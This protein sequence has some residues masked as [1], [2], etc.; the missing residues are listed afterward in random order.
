MTTSAIDHDK[1]SGIIGR[2]GEAAIDPAAWPA[3]MDDLCRATGTTGAVLLQADIRTPDVPSTVSM[4]E[5]LQRYFAQGWH[6]ADP[7]ARGVPRAM[8]GEVITDEDCV[9]PDQ[10]RI[11]PMYNEVLRPFGLQWFAGIGFWAGS[12]SWVLT[13]QRTSREGAFDARDTRILAQL[14]PRLTETATLSTSIGRVA[15]AGMTDALDRVRKPA[16]IIDRLG[17]VLS[18]NA[19]AD[20]G[21]DDEIK[22][23]NRQLVVHDKQAMARIDRL[24]D[25]I[26]FSSESTA[27]PHE[28]V[29]IRRTAKPPVVLRVLPIDGA[30][31]NVFLGAR[32][33]LTLSNLIPRLPPEPG[34]IAQAF[35]LTRAEARLVSL[36][37]TG[38]SLDAAAGRL[39]IA[40]ETA[41]NHL[42]SA[43]SKTGTH[44]QAELISLIAHL[45]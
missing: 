17:Q 32:A 20:A 40:R 1:L 38:L 30:A 33:M 16:L 28:P 37:V 39:G 8:S 35:E 41:R 12:A 23:R 44:R 34:L 24:I 27:R 5:A 45:T 18:R 26:R 42:K 9:T 4:N 15:L 14:A 29:M 43:F 7:R 31:R 10:M 13:L 21:F 6:L 36:L 2:L 3:I 22:L 19:A 11:D 25:A